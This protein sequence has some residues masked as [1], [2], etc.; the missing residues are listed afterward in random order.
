[1][2]NNVLNL[3]KKAKKYKN[4]GFQ[5]AVFLRRIWGVLKLVS[6]LEDAL[7]LVSLYDDACSNDSANFIKHKNLI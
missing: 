7:T 6:S 1:M 5:N 2:Q 4:I 3:L